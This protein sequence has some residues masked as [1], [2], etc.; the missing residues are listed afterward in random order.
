MFDFAEDFDRGLP[1]CF[2]SS[3]IALT[4]SGF[5]R[6]IVSITRSADAGVASL[7]GVGV[8]DARVALLAGVGVLDAGVLAELLSVAFED[9]LDAGGDTT[10]GCSAAE[11]ALD[12]VT[13]D[14]VRPVDGSVACEDAREG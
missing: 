4:S 12:V 13:L 11:G 9:C 1:F 6:S 10:G 5:D 14:D 7:A 2:N 8:L 3:S